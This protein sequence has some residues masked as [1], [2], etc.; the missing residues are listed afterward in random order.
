MFG[1]AWRVLLLSV[2][3]NCAGISA[4][5]PAL[6][7]AAEPAIH[8]DTPMSPPAWALLERELLRANAAA[9]REFFGKYF[10][11]RGWLLCVER[12]GGDDGPDDAIENCNDWPL[13]YALGGADDVRQMYQRAWEGHLRQ[14]TLAKTTEVPLARD[15]MFYKEFHTQFDWMHLG[16][17]LTVFNVMGLAGLTPANQAR[18]RRFAGLYMNED[19]QAQ[20]YDPRH[21]IIRSLFNGSRGPLLRKA[22]ALD[23]AGDPIEVEHRFTLGHGERSYQEMLEHFQDYNDIVGDSPQNLRATTLAFNAFALTGD[24]K[25]QRWVLEYVDAWRQRAEAN[26][27]IMP[28]NVGLD[29]K[30]GSETGGKW[31]GGVYGWGFSVKVPRTGEIAHRNRTMYGFAGLANALL[32]TGDHR[33]L[34][35]WRRQIDAIN[36]QR[37]RQGDRWIYPRMHGDNGWYDWQPQ[38]YSENALEMYALSLREDDRE[39]VPDSGWL[40]FLRGERGD[41]P[42]TA[43]RRDLARVRTR[44][45]AMRQD[46]TT[47]DTRLADDPMKFNPCSVE[48]LLEL[49]LGGV[50]PGVGGNVLIAQLR[51]FDYERRR[52]GL[53]DDVAALVEKLTADEATVTL[54]NT[55]QLQPRTLIVQGGPYAEHEIVAAA[56]GGRE[57]PVG[58]R[59]VRITLAP[60]AGSQLT[61]RLKRHAHPPTLNQPL[62]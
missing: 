33:Y 48:S 57:T 19:P 1:P 11:E 5:L 60:G 23:W 44:I 46:P 26:G 41:Y 35:T 7:I 29:G 31:Y 13:L 22:T 34:D 2:L 6:T 3:A 42:E 62:P 43:L 38:P 9:C 8:I 36:A 28:S 18:V 27:G 12:W 56:H 4:G 25:Y 32:L 51:Y 24:E 16:E 49:T 52:A 20:N 50:H 39:R 47:P 10:D 40:E 54:V 14:Y 37:R 17:E 21:K 59:H 55:N 45:A 53:P 30:I 58:R 15:G 61:L